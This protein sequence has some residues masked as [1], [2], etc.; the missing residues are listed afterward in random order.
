MSSR[1]SRVVLP[2]LLFSILLV[3]GGLWLFG[4]EVPIGSRLT[5][6]TSGTAAVTLACIGVL[7]VL[8]YGMHG[9][10]AQQLI[11]RRQ[12]AR[13]RRHI[14]QQPCLTYL[15]PEGVFFGRLGIDRETGLDIASDYVGWDAAPPFR[16]R[17]LR[18]CPGVPLMRG[19]RRRLAQI[20]F[21]VRQ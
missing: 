13:L 8:T 16:R 5:V 3:I 19:D 9:L 14:E 11:Q 4:E 18:E 15:E 17:P 6:F 1:S 10:V 20:F 7:T 21:Y 12:K 2:A